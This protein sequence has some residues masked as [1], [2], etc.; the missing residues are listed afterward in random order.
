MTRPA[1]L[2]RLSASLDAQVVLLAAPSG[3]GKTTLLAQYAR[4][5]PRTVVWCRLTEGHASPAD[6]A[7]LIA[8]AVAPHVGPGVLPADPRT[9][10]QALLG[11][12]VE[13][14]AD[15]D[16]N[17]DLIVDP[18]E[19]DAVARWL[20]SLGLHLTEGHRVLLS[21]YSAEGL[22]LARACAAGQAEVLDATDLQFSEQ[23]T[24]HLLK[25]RDVDLDPDTLRQLQGW[26]AGLALSA[27]TPQRLV[28]SADLVKDLLDTLPAELQDGLRDLAPLDTWS[29]ADARTLNVT[30]P[31]G[32]LAQVQRTGLPLLPLEPGVFQP[33]RLLTQVLE[34]A[35]ARCPERQRAVF[36]QAAA[37]AEARSEDRRAARLYALAGADADFNRVAAPLTA[38]YRGRGEHHLI[39]DLLAHVPAARLAPALLARLAWA[40]IETGD[41]ATGEQALLD[42]R[43]AGQLPPSGYASLAMVAG[44]RGDVDDQHRYAAEGQA[45]LAPG[46]VE[47]ALSWPLVYAALKRGAWSQAQDAA[48]TMMTWALR[49]GDPVRVAEAWQLQAVVT[50]AGPAPQDAA[51]ALA[52]ARDLYDQLGWTGRVSML[53]LE[54]AALALQGGH[55]DAARHALAHAVAGTDP[56]QH[57]HH[58]RRHLLNATLALRDGAPVDAAQALEHARVQ[59]QRGAPHLHALF[60]LVHADLLVLRGEA[61][62]AAALLPEEVPPDL[63]PYRDLLTALLP[64]GEVRF[65]EADVLQWRDEGWKARALTRLARPHLAV[66][67]GPLTAPAALPG[68]ALPA[69]PEP[70]GPHLVITA[71]DDVHVTLAGRPVPV[72]LAKSRELL[73]W[74]ALH[75]SGTRSEIV[76]A[77]WDG[78]EEE[79]HVEYFRVAVRRLRGALKAAL[80]ADLDPLPYRDGRYRLSADLTVTLDA[81][82]PGNDSGGWAAQFTAL[83]RTFLP[84]TE[85]D[86][87]QA[88]RDRR[89]RAAVT[90]GLQVAGHSAPQEAADLYRQVLS[91]DPWNDAAHQGAVRALVALN[92]PALAE[93]ALNRYAEILNRDLGL[94]PDAGFMTE[95]ARA[96]LH[97][98]PRRAGAE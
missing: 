33:H 4:S 78:S 97:V 44:R 93:Q 86:W 12:L 8:S 57:R 23:E 7:R 60:T 27:A 1:L 81:A 92:H 61:S 46:D 34:Q 63:R 21:R 77:L 80:D 5:T 10:E 42:L 53:R 87:V 71:L 20:V 85:A 83:S 43:A 89:H 24:R 38:G 6:V 84:G 70:A 18:V 16:V 22:R 49:Q 17:L 39:R 13:A 69:A 82:Q 36:R 66:P 55:L 98:T 79:R 90:L 25:A 26:P 68:T 35:L 11:A 40:Q 31:D 88:E 47:P 2:R 15:A 9:P 75:G 96:G 32:W 56:E 62:A 52:A 19:D 28:R 74:L 58:A 14:L 94:Q 64:G 65:S 76:T 48:R 59:V 45:R 37:L 67:G 50:Q 3:Y 54:E 29:E 95:M 41:A 51:R 91:L 73:V 72:A 30:L